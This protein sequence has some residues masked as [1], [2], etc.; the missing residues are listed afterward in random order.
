MKSDIIYLSDTRLVSNEGV[1]GDE[2]V[3]AA[4]RGSGIC[5]YYSFFNSSANK[6]GTGILFK[7][8]LEFK[9][10]EEFKDIEENFYF[11]RAEIKG[12]ELL[13][14]S[15]YGPNTVN[16]AFFLRI[17]KILLKHTNIPV[18]VGG[19]W[20]ATYDCSKIND[21]IDTYAM[22]GLPNITHS[23]LISEMCAGA[24]LTDPYRALFPTRRDFSYMPFG[25]ARVNRSRIDYFLISEGLINNVVRCEMSSS[26]NCKLFDHKSV[27][28]DFTKP[29]K[30]SEVK[31]TNFAINDPFLELIVKKSVFVFHAYSLD[32]EEDNNNAFFAAEM[33]K[34]D[35][36]SNLMDEMWQLKK[37]SAADGET[38]LARNMI[39]A[40]LAEIKLAWESVSLL[41]DF[42]TRK[43]RVNSTEFFISFIDFIK[44]ETAR[45]QKRLRNLFGVQK[46]S[47]ER[48]LN[49]FKKDFERNF[50]E[51]F[52]LEKKLKK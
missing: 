25:D 41:S 20:N 37:D 21:N 23:K 28:L 24:N 22:A 14:G 40:K 15:I 29:K 36:L 35:N 50:N 48:R 17:R 5:K 16:R 34:L 49:E 42:E 9:V 10:L 39:S 30:S 2:R 12:K 8:D 45:A 27:L 38:R 19:D 4:F 44:T 7:S 26:V 13:L 18:I 31:I 33:A 51:I 46:Q 32:R 6:R 3:T 1:A 47:V 43:K 52:D 11:I